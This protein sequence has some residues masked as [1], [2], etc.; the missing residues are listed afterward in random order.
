MAGAWR[1]HDG[2]AARGERG[3]DVMARTF[4]QWVRLTFLFQ[5]LLYCML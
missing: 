2:L 3:D 4:K 1:W 5:I